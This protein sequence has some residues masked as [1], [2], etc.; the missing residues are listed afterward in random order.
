MRKTMRGLTLVALIATAAAA[1]EEPPPR[2]P[3][4]RRTWVAE[5]RD[6]AIRRRQEFLKLSPEEQQRIRTERR[7]ERRARRFA[8]DATGEQRSALDD[9]GPLAVR[10]DGAGGPPI[11]EACP[12]E[13]ACSL[14]FVPPS[15]RAAV[16]TGVWSA[17]KV[18]C[19]GHVTST[20]RGGGAVAPWWRCETRLTVEG[21]GAGYVGF[22]TSR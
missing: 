18:E 19:D 17:T 10:V 8:R 12:G 2:D 4:A 7:E 6:E 15:G 11:G 5:K 21:P 3:V 9:R 14:R 22:L 16:I 20:P 1:A 13:A